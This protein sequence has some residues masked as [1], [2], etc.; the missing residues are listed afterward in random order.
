MIPRS[1]SNGFPGRDGLASRFALAN[2]T[3]AKAEQRS[4]HHVFWGAVGIM[5]CRPFKLLT[6]LWGELAADSS[7]PYG[8]DL[9]A[10]VRCRRQGG[11]LMRCESNCWPNLAAGI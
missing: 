4:V 8:W 1:R 9:L 3:G 10:L 5:G 6:S 11:G 7:A 2:V